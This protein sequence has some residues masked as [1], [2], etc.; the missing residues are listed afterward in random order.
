MRRFKAGVA[1]GAMLALILAASIASAGNVR[2][3]GTAG[4]QELRIPVGSRG[5]SLGGAAIADVSGIDALYWNPA[6][7]VASKKT[8]AMFSRLNYIAG[9]SVNYVAAS[10]KVSDAIALGFSAKVLSVGDLVVTT[11][12]SPEGTGEVLSPTSAV[13][14]VTYSHQLTDRI[15]FGTTGKYINEDIA[16]ETAS[17][18][19][20]DLGFQYAPGV[21]GL[22]VALVMK[23]IGPSMR[24]DGPDLE[25]KVQLPGTD[26]QSRRR[27]VRTRLES[28]ELPTSMELGASYDLLK[29]D[30]SRAVLVAA[31]RNNN[32][33]QD[34]YQAGLEYSLGK[35][36]FL[37]GGYLLSKNETDTPDDFKFVFGPTFGFGLRVP[38]S[39]ADL[40]LDYSQAS[41]DFFDDSQ[42]FTVQFAF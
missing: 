4:A 34:E 14:G 24:F 29:N 36:L 25:S 10:A 28:F 31:F 8:E 1:A 20:F 26:P 33:S 35:T 42:W 19:A 22:R 21:S 7:V 6:G 30:D 12:D 18:L 9:M 39:G 38:L 23:N 5:A 37:R 2:R 13:V 11:E 17:G 27:T 16:R 15:M 41:A 40:T 32:L 3:T